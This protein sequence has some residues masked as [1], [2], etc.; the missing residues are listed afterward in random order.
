MAKLSKYYKVTNQMMIEYISDQYDQNPANRELVTSNVD[1]RIYEGLD[2]N[3][4]YT[5]PAVLTQDEQP[6]NKYDY[7]DGQIFIKF[8]DKSD[9]EYVFY[10]LLKDEDTGIYS[11]NDLIQEKLDDPDHKTVSSCTEQE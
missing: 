9:S 10:G 4:Y 3:I 6:T 7:T 2:G 8:G 5:E 1:Y 11:N